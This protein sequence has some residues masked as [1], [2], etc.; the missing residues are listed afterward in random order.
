S[1]HSFARWFLPW[2]GVDTIKVTIRNISSTIEIIKNKTRDAI[3]ALQTEI[4]SLSKAVLQI[5]MALDLLVAS[6][7]RVCTIINTSCC[8]Y[9]DRSGRVTTDLN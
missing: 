4:T 7:G 1:F 8:I 6:Q 2:L 5:R 9:V 3:E